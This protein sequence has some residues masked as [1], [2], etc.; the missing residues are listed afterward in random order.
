MIKNV[1]ER[2][3]GVGWL[4]QSSWHMKPGVGFVPVVRRI[5]RGLGDD[6]NRTLRPFVYLFASLTERVACSR[7][8]WKAALGGVSNT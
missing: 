5:A 6:R 2:A 4:I 3:R 8:P 1:A 7:M